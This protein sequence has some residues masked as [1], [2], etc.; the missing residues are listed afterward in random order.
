MGLFG[1]FRPNQIRLPLTLTLPN[2]VDC[3]MRDDMAVTNQQSE[4]RRL[5]YYVYLFRRTHHFHLP[6][7]LDMIFASV[8]WPCGSSSLYPSCPRHVKPDKT[9]QP[10]AA[11]D[12]C[13]DT[14]RDL[15]CDSCKLVPQP[16]LGGRTVGAEDPVRCPST[17]SKRR[18]RLFVSYLSSQEEQL[19][20]E[21]LSRATSYCAWRCVPLGQILT[22]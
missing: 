16:F 19:H 7:G 11:S 15:L 8:D 21:N 22:R 10:P 6:E 2:K 9:F 4:L 12:I 20:D 13:G 18:E 1:I 3:D 5:V 17:Q 14:R